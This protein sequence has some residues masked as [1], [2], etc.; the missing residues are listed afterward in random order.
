MYR[1]VLAHPDFSVTELT[2][3]LSWP[4]PTVRHALTELAELSLLYVS[5][6][7]G[8]LRVLSPQL[9]LE[10][11]FAREQAEV[12]RRQ[13]ELEARRAAADQ[14]LSE[15]ADLHR[16][17]ERPT[18]ERLTGLDT[19][20]KRIAA[21]VEGTSREAATFAPGGPQ[22]ADNRAA[23]RPVAERAIARGITSRTVYLDSV[24]NDSASVEYA[25][26]LVSRGNQVRTAPSLPMRMHIFDCEAALVPIDPDDSAKGAVLIREPGAV[27]AFC[28]LFEAMWA[29]ASPLGE[30][31]RRGLHDPGSQHRELLRLLAQG[32]TDEAAARR[33]GVSL[34]TE[35][36][37]ISELMEQLQARS[38]F[39]LGQRAMEHGLL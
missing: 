7:A 32:F 18:V 26:W 16:E 6:D 17:A 1:T 19:V 2:E 22:P 24:R 4:E 13:Q 14:F 27:T 35:R 29:T 21:L 15:Y 5:A 9:A 36:R 3:F 10:A 34:R 25:T 11:L 39:Q 38:R 12:V 8:K 37:L 30:T 28:A 23:S 20:R 33:L 31:P